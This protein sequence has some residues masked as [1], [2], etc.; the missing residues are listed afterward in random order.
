MK[1]FN[2]ALL[3]LAL[4][5]PGSRRPA[6]ADGTAAAIGHGTITI[7]GARVG[8]S[9]GAP[10]LPATTTRPITTRRYY[11]PPAVVAAPAP[12]YIEQGASARA[13]RPPPAQSQ[14]AYWYYCRDTQTYYPY[15]QQCA[16]PW[17]QVVPHSAPPS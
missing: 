2:I 17:Q 9:F 15:V 6:D 11:Y 14:S 13:R 10:L 8:V 1:T 3:S 5:R 7:H 16:S 12:V 4:S